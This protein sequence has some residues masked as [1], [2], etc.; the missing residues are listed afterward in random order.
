VHKAEIICA[1]G[2]KQFGLD[3]YAAKDG[4]SRSIIWFEVGKSNNDPKCNAEYYIGMIEILKHVPSI[5]RADCGTE[6]THIRSLQH[7]IRRNNSES[8]SAIKSSMFGRRNSNQQIEAWWSYL[9]RQGI[10]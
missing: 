7:S 3:I 9:R 10:H 6:N 1:C 4:Y 2:R 8:M 5:V